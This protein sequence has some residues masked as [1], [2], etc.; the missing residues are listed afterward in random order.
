M[1]DAREIRR[2]T[3]GSVKRAFQ[4]G[5]SRRR[6]AATMSGDIRARRP[7]TG[8]RL[9]LTAGPDE[10]SIAEPSTTDRDGISRRPQ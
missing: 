2:L 5:F 7:A 1:D 3:T 10:S 8:C 6:P 9:G 4:A